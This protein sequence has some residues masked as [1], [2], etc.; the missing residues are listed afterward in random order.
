MKKIALNFNIWSNSVNFVFFNILIYNNFI[1]IMK[2]T[3]KIAVLALISNSS[4]RHAFHDDIYLQF[5]DDGLFNDEMPNPTIGGPNNDEIYMNDDNTR[6]EKARHEEMMAQ[7]PRMA[8][9]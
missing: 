4:A 1:L 2:Q 6:L 9:V 8:A 7:Q 5:L 3:N